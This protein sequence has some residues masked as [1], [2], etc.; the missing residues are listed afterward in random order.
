MGGERTF[1]TVR[2]FVSRATLLVAVVELELKRSIRR[3]DFYE[4][5]V[6]YS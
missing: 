6:N 5:P 3:F 2:A 4:T 1:P